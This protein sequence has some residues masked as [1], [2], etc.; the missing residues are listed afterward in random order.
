[1][2][3]A[4]VDLTDPGSRAAASAERHQSP[5][6]PD[7]P[8]P[9]PLLSLLALADAVMHYV[10]AVVLLVVAVIVLW[11][12]AAELA[13]S[14]QP[15]VTATTTAVNAVLF[16]IIILEVIRTIA[17]HLRHGGFQLRPFLIIG[18]ISAIR[19]IL[20][21]GARLS[22]EGT[23]LQPSSAVVR[24]SLL[25]LAVSAAV[26]LSLALALALLARVGG[27]NDGES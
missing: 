5:G 19:S 12:A 8:L 11:H 14:R 27:M 17:T 1:M 24:T 22:L 6:A 25:E 10:V 16:T 3:D 13:S 18:T 15:L 7:N 4:G 9:R 26:V 23:H 20:A 21:V 2:S